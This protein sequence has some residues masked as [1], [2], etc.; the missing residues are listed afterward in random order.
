[1]KV[2]LPILKRV[3]ELLQVSGDQR[4]G[5]NDMYLDPDT[6]LWFIDAFE[7]PTWHWSHER[8]TFERYVQREQI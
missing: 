2:M 3:Y 8:S 6:H 5:V 4:T 1:M 7:M